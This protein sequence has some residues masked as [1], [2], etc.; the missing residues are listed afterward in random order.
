MHRYLN[1]FIAV[2]VALGVASILACGGKSPTAL[3]VR[4]ASGTW[5]AAN[6]VPG[7]GERWTLAISGDAVSG[8][9]DWSGEAC[10]GGT[11][12]IAGSIRGD[13]LHLDITYVKTL[14]TPSPGPY[15]HSHVDAVLD[16]PTDLVG[17]GRNDGGITGVV[18][19]VRQAQ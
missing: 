11:L 1:P 12:T 4:T 19:F 3:D 2:V 17:T 8:T 16:T 13:S 9:G 7:S 6:E 10:C 15:S 18:H 5:V 14:P